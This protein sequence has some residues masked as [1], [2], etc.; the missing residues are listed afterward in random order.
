MAYCIVL[1][2]PYYHHSTDALLGSTSSVLTEYGAFETEAW[3]GT[4]AHLLNEEHGDSDF[5]FFARP[6]DDPFG[7]DSRPHARGRGAVTDDEDYEIPF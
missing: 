4:K 2:Q 6:S 3:A 5:H 7:F 1:T